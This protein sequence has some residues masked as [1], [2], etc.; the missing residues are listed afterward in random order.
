MTGRMDDVT[1][2]E[3]GASA[4]PTDGDGAGTTR[5]RGR[6]RV[7]LALAAG[8][9]V[10]VV[11][12]L[13]V[14]HRLDAAEDAR[15]ARAQQVPGVVD[16]L[17][18]PPQVLW[19]PDAQTGAEM[20]G[21]ASL[22]ASARVGGTIVVGHLEAGTTDG[23][24]ATLRG[25]D[26]A[27]GQV[28]WTQVV[29]GPAEPTAPDVP[30]DLG[31]VQC[32]ALHGAAGSPVACLLVWP[33]AA[34]ADEDTG[35]VSTW[36]VLEAS[37]GTVQH[38]TELPAGASGAAT[39]ALLVTAVREGDHAEV[40]AVRPDG[41]AVWTAELPA[42]ASPGTSAWVSADGTG[43]EVR[44]DDTT[45]ALDARGQ[46][47]APSDSALLIVGITSRGRAASTTVGTAGPVT[48]VVGADGPWT[49]A[50]GLPATLVVDDASDPD[51]EV[52]DSSL[53]GGG[54]LSVADSSGTLWDST[55]PG[56]DPI[57]LD[58][59]LYTH[60]GSHAQARDLRTGRVLWQADL[61]SSNVSITT[62]GRDL[63]VLGSDGTIDAYA[64]RDGSRRWSTRIEQEGGLGV[65]A[66]RL[67]LV[68][69][70]DQ[71]AAVLG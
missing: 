67:V 37:T 46:I 38:R 40:T 49:A 17:S 52:L 60:D 61:P 70:I 8:L 71:V 59:R 34:G 15:V 45:W 44:S 29:A 24:T 43:V 16:E 4:A 41:D 47:T 31:A 56:F 13:V 5:G 63:L 14:Q 36:V 30:P 55:L 69:G 42:D 58:G 64:L 35:T 1:L 11:A 66:D 68:E 50:E 33:P 3:E 57:V 25:L 20:L 54:L 10:V 23:G 12:L 2:L 27:T 65:V 19:A 6:R 9:A 48:T 18:G 62:D 53:G 32:T 26:A 21:L 39:D 51:L 22:P 7:L 28:T